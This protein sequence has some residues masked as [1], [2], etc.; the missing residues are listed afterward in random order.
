MGNIALVSE[1]RFCMM[2]GEN[3][4]VRAG[5]KEVG[6]KHRISLYGMWNCLCPR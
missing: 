6:R 2:I 3:E 1:G 4:G 5:G